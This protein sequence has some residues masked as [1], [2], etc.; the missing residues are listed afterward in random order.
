ME[1]NLMKDQIALLENFLIVIQ[2]TLDSDDHF[3]LTLESG[4]SGGS[5]C[6]IE[7]P[8]RLL[9]SYVASLNTILVLYLS[10]G[11]T[12]SIM[13]HTSENSVVT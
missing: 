4:R 11:T 2:K 5:S 3:I 13:H 12:A 7:L 6:S 9:P 8:K 1:P 10:S